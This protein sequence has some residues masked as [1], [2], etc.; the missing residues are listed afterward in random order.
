LIVVCDPRPARLRR[1]FRR[2]YPDMDNGRLTE[3]RAIRDEINARLP[4]AEQSN[5]LHASDNAEEAWEYVRCAVPE[6]E[7][8]LR[9]A[10]GGVRG[11]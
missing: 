1:R 2:R 8:E 7:A 10:A 4:A 3:K 9:A 11:R 5:F 6:R